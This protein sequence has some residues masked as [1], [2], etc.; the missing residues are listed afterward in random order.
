M[1]GALLLLPLVGFMCLVVGI[2]LVFYLNSNSKS[3]SNSDDAVGGDDIANNT[4]N[5]TDQNPGSTQDNV[6]PP[7]GNMQVRSGNAQAPGTYGNFSVQRNGLYLLGVP[8]RFQY[9]ERFGF[10]GET[11]LQMLMLKYGVWIP[12]EIARSSGSGNPNEDLLPGEPNYP[13]A[14]RNLK[15]RFQLFTGSGYKSFIVWAKQW[16]MKGVGIVF[17]VYHNEG[18][19]SEYDHVIPLVGIQTQTT[20]FSDS[21]VLYMNTDYAVKNVLRKVN[22]FSCT[23]ATARTQHYTNGGCVPSNIKPTWAIAIM[24][25]LYLGIGP[26]LEL[27]M[28]TPREPGLGK[29]APISGTVKIRDLVPGKSYRLY[30]VTNAAQVPSAPNATFNG[31]LLVTFTASSA[32][33]NYNVSFQS[34]TPQWFICVPG[35]K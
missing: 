32:T 26:R 20:G 28:H 9:N 25:P 4:N 33:Y 2:A 19:D 16:L 31:R 3:K 7:T 5:T 15:I 22:G 23:R 35:G 12:Q 10:C 30:V 17:P 34:R 27:V 24:G 21:D 6:A 14:L 13:N 11:S 18:S 29:S 8:G 1:S